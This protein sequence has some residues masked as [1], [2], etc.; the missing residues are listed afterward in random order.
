MAY[1]LII[2]SVICLL[3]AAYFAYKAWKIDLDEDDSN[4]PQGDR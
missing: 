3:G 1:A 4:P 2:G